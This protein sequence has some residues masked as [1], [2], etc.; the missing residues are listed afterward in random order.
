MGNFQ[1]FVIIVLPVYEWDS[2][3]GVFRANMG[4][5]RPSDLRQ[6][7]KNSQPYEQ[8]VKSAAPHRFFFL[9]ELGGL[10]GGVHS[11]MTLLL[12]LPS[13][14]VFSMDARVSTFET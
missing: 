5:L 11:T 3:D 6:R 10:S 12:L 7:P 9:T 13:D 14:I 4:C 1:F 8:R 2:F